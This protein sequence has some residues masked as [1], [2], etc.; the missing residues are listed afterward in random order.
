M[1]A[2]GRTV[3]VRLQAA[4]TAAELRILGGFILAIALFLTLAGSQLSSWRSVGQDLFANTIFSTAIAFSCYTLVRASGALQDTRPWRRA[5]RLIGLLL[6]GALIGTAVARG[7]VQL[8][9]GAA[10]G[11]LA[12]R[13]LL[14][15]DVVAALFFGVAIQGYFLLRDRLQRIAALLA[16]REVQ[17]QRLVQ[18]R[19]R[20]ELA[21]LRAKINPHFLFN[22]L[23]SIA[24]LIPTD[25]AAAEDMVQK[26]AHVFRYVLDASNREWVT[27]DEELATVERYL[28]IERVRLG[29]R[30]RCRID[31]S[32]GART[33]R[34]PAL[35]L[36]PLV[37]NAVKHG[38]APSAEGGE[39]TVACRLADGQCLIVVSDTGPGLAGQPAF[40]FGLR[41]VR[42]R[43]DLCYGDGHQFQIDGSDGVHVRLSIPLTPPEPRDA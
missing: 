29:Q 35:L 10:A 42:E 19:T 11:P 38:I 37:E 41:S 6:L 36:Q 21:S 12:W 1:N 15:F 3:R 14:R 17:A 4:W 16:A 33:V 31:V 23:N 30:L 40:G 34:L 18:A 43:L 13:P 39:I 25:P 27:L 32:E 24:G 28:A 22:T 9:L 8:T 2:D 20:A 5:L 7:S 26:L